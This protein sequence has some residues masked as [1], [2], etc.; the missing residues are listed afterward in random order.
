[1]FDFFKKGKPDDVKGI[2]HAITDFVKENLQKAAGGEGGNIQVIYLYLT[3]QA[4]DRALYEAA[5]YAQEE[6]RFK[7]EEVQKIADD[8]GVALPNDWSLKIE[9]T[10]VA[11]E[12]AVRSGNVDAALFIVSKD[13]PRIVANAHAIINVLNGETEQ[14]TY[15][16]A[17]S[18]GKINI[19][20]ESR[21]QTSDNFMR[22]N[23]I[24]FIGNSTQSC[25]RSVSR[26]HAHLEYNPLT[27]AFY[28][29]ADEGGVPP[30]NKVKVR[31]KNNEIFR[32]QTTLVG[33]RLSDEDQ[34]ILGESALLEFRIAQGS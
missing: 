25:N 34:I 22:L 4:I 17:A 23:H 12:E 29:F 21:V 32:L 30:Q 9:F 10:S 28:I 8:Y 7:E 15:T 31:S 2:R 1:M 20:R 16:I 11:P 33:H 3:C 14:A 13:K 5:V 24:A 26:Q 19:G 27:G 18:Q 6:N